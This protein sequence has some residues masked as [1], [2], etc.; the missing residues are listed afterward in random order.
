VLPDPVMS[1]R[2]TEVELTEPLPELRLARDQDGFGL[3]ARL[4]DRLI[5]FVLHPAPPG[6]TLNPLEMQRLVDR[7]FAM[8][9]LETTTK[10]MLAQRMRIQ[11]DVA[12][13]SLTIVVSTYDPGP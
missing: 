6:S 8:A 4:H 13:P 10:S 12:P 1:Y 5:G 2:I 7:H 9:V 11:P 3:I